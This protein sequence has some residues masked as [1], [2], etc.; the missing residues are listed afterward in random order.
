MPVGSAPGFVST[1]GEISPQIQP[2]SSNNSVQLVNASQ[3]LLLS[4]QS[5]LKFSNPVDPTALALSINE[6]ITQGPLAQTPGPS[7]PPAPGQSAAQSSSPNVL[8][9][10]SAQSAPPAPVSGPS[11]APAPGSGPSSAPAPGSGPSAAPSPVSGPSAAPAP[12]SGKSSAPAQESGSPAAIIPLVINASSP[13]LESSIEPGTIRTLSASSINDFQTNPNILNPSGIS[14][15]SQGLVGKLEVQEVISKH[16]TE[17]VLI[18]ANNPVNLMTSGPG[19][20]ANTPYSPGVYSEPSSN[21]SKNTQAEVGMIILIQL[22]YSI[23]I[24]L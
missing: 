14:E 7:V 12:G 8:T 13:I 20:D 11:A 2:I 19:T 9:P 18:D 4:D 24:Q 17:P 16:D 21:L 23:L 1:P 22:Q 6:G 3:S 5:R 15:P 10:G